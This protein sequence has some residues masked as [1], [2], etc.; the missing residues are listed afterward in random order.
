[1]KFCRKRAVPLSLFLALFM[2]QLSVPYQPV[3][4]AMISTDACLG[5]TELG[6]EREQIRQF[7]AQ[8]AVRKAFIA[9]GVTPDEVEARLAGLSDAEILEISQEIENLP[10]GGDSVGL[11]I[12]VLLIVLLVIVILRLI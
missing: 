3:M 2:L 4:A 9:H 1:M 10:A 8:D 7:L 12:A 5:S 11:V 6:P